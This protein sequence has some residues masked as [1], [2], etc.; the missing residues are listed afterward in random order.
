M[1]TVYHREKTGSIEL[2]EKCPYVFLPWLFGFNGI[3]CCQVEFVSRSLRQKSNFCSRHL[4]NVLYGA[5]STRDVFIVIDCSTGNFTQVF[6]FKQI[7][8]QDQGADA[9]KSSH[10]S[11]SYCTANKTG[12][13]TLRSDLILNW[14]Q[15]HIDANSCPYDRYACCCVLRGM[16]LFRSSGNHPP[17]GQQRSRSHPIQIRQGGENGCPCLSDS[18]PHGRRP[19]RGPVI[20]D[21]IDHASI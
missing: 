2:L 15:P 19:D 5:L 6:R 18:F 14:S 21:C 12:E 1:V 20:A 3:V 16:K 17:K 7:Q 10:K 4:L 9:G 8:L 13:A 11:V